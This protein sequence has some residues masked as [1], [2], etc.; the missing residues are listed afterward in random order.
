MSRGMSTPWGKLPFDARAM[1]TPDEIQESGGAVSCVHCRIAPAGLASTGAADDRRAPVGA[2]G[3]QAKAS[4]DILHSGIVARHGGSGRLQVQRE[5][6]N[7]VEPDAVQ[8]KR[9][10]IGTER[11]VFPCVTGGESAATNPVANVGEGAN[12]AEAAASVDPASRGPE[13]LIASRPLTPGFTG[14]DGGRDSSVVTL[15]E[16]PGTS[17]RPVTA[18]ERATSSPPAPVFFKPAAMILLKAVAVHED[19]PVERLVLD[20]VAAKARQIGL[21]T[22]ARAVL[23][24][25]DGEHSRAPP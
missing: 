10:E 4:E 16:T 2:V 3:T 18:P 25:V 15:S 20:L 12:G 1:L 13:V 7:A 14:E 6:T 24:R 19:V 5:P 11:G 9:E 17:S 22:L 21:S 23:D 8:S